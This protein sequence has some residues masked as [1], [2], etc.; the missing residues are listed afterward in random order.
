MDSE[1]LKSAIELHDSVLASV[2][3]EGRWVKIKLAPAYIHKSAGIPGIDPGTG[4]T[5]DALLIV[6][7]GAIEGRIIELPC[8]LS[9]G[10]LQVAG[11]V[12]RNV[13]PLPL[14]YVG[15]IELTLH[16][17]GDGEIVVRGTR[18]FAELFGEPTYIE[19]FN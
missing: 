13:L 1:T 9:D 12:L 18:I 14:D 8:D 19:E 11:E 2:G 3:D 17:K 10:T 5:Q 6:E 15:Q 16:F 4:W 7:D